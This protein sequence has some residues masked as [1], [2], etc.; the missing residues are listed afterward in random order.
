MIPS[1]NAVSLYERIGGQAAVQAYSGA[2]MRA[3]HGRLAI[4]Q[5]DFDAVASHLVQ[6]LRELNLPENIISEVPAALTPLSSQ[7]VASTESAVA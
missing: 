7:I 3:A 4:E 6:T 5:P 1:T 2:S